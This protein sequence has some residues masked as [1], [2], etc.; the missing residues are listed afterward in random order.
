MAVMRR[1]NLRFIPVF[2]LFLLPLGCELLA[3]FNVLSDEEEIALGKKFTAEIE[4]EKPPVQDPTLNWYAQDI[5]SRIAATALQDRPGIPYTFK[6]VA[7][8][9]I[10]AYALPG[11]PVYIHTG[12]LAAAENEYEVIGVLGHEIG[13][14]VGKH[15]AKQ[16]SKQA[17]IQILL[18]SALGKDGNDGAK[19]AG[20]LLG[21]FMLLSYSREDEYEADML[22]LKYSVAAGYRPEGLMELFKKIQ[23][24]Q[25]GGDPGAIERMLSTHPPTGER[26]ARVQQWVAQN[27]LPPTLVIDRPL[28]RQIKARL[29]K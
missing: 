22:G 13:H 18:D 12:L 4:K 11:G 24:N 14:V 29:P 6:V 17:G 5:G 8:K 9:S 2:V 10:N 21:N 15:G 23:A 25:G 7:D 19:T 27:P 16:I 20:T 26:I 3:N 1:K 28:F